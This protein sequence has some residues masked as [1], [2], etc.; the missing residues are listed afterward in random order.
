MVCSSRHM[1]GSV[2]WVPRDAGLGHAGWDCNRLIGVL[3]STGTRASIV[4]A[5]LRTRGYRNVRI[6][7]GGCEAVVD[8][9][10]EDQWCPV[11]YDLVRGFRPIIDSPMSEDMGHPSRGV[12]CRKGFYTSNDAQKV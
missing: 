5:Y 8:A 3:R 6:V 11:D 12:E 9:M 7:R 4:Y 10:I 1:T 2:A